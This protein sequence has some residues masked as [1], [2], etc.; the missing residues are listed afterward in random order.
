MAEQAITINNIEWRSDAVRAK[1]GQLLSMAYKHA[2]ISILHIS[3]LREI[4]S[5]TLS[6]KDLVASLHDPKAIFVLESASREDRS[7]IGAN[8]RNTSDKV[9]MTI[10]GLRAVDGG[11]W[12]KMYTSRI[13]DLENVN[14]EYCAHSKAFKNQDAELLM[15]SK[16]DQDFLIEGLIN[17]KEP[18]EDLRRVFARK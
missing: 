9:Q 13:A 7:K 10:A 6:M 8:L 18:S 12:K 4:K 16:A 11:S 15:L 5:L 14:R 1:S 17:P 2:K 3:I